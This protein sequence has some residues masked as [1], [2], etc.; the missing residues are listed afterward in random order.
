MPSEP[1]ISFPS[2]ACDELLCVFGETIGAPSDPCES[3]A[4]CTEMSG[5]IDSF[6]CENKICTVAQEAVL[7]RSMCST[8]CDS[9]IECADFV[10]GTRCES[11]FTCAP[12]M[13]LGDFCCQKVCVC[14]DGLDVAASDKLEEA[15]LAREV[16]GC[17]NR[18]PLPKGCG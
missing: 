14:R 11:G 6:V 7:E 9:D 13:S 2:L 10:D 15:C 16:P 4:D 3:D 5:G 8:T 18:E 17:C 1:V 12:L